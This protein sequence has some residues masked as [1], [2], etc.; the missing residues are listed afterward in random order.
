MNRSKFPEGPRYKKH[1]LRWLQTQLNA[2]AQFKKMLSDH[3]TLCH[4]KKNLGAK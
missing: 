3:K 2:Q 4:T 1:R